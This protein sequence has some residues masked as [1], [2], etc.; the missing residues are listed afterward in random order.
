MLLDPKN[1][2]VFYTDLNNDHNIYRYLV[3]INY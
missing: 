3:L 1:L 2:I